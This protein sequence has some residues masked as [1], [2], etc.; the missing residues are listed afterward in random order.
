MTAGEVLR[1]WLAHDH[2]HLRQLHR[3][4]LSPQVSQGSLDYDSGW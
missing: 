2:L 1:A 4:S 3:Q